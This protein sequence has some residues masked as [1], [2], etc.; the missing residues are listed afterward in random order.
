[1]PC[2]EIYHS[3]CNALLRGTVGKLDVHTQFLLMR[4]LGMKLP[5]GYGQPSNPT[6]H[7]PVHDLPT[8]QTRIED[9]F[10][11]TFSK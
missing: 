8:P 5:D 6:L 3:I 2:R 11:D 4:K 9:T 10:S 1:M 7:F